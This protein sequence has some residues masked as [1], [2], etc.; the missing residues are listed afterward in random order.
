MLLLHPRTDC[1][2]D[3]PEQ[4]LLAQFS[5]PPQSQL[6]LRIE[7]A[8]VPHESAVYS[9]TSLKVTI[10]TFENSVFTGITVAALTHS[11]SPASKL[12]QKRKR[13]IS[14]TTTTPSSLPQQPPPTD[15]VQWQFPPLAL[16]GAP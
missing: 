11:P 4:T 7:E 16:L 3:T 15:T 8:H 9:S 13:L 12:D 10:L 2:I 14:T 6:S 5:P 1:D